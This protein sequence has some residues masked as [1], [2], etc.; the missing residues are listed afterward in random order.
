MLSKHKEFQR[1]LGSK[2]VTYDSTMKIGRILKDRCPKQDI[3]LL[4]NMMDEL[5][6]RWNKICSKSVN[7]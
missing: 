1:T 3:Q 6:T 2:Q 7:R 4:Q 5:K